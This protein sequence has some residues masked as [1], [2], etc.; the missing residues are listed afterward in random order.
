M[1]F[2]V[3]F[4]LVSGTRSFCG[5]LFGAMP[6]D[7]FIN[8]R[9]ESCFLRVV[10]PTTTTPTPRLELINYHQDSTCLFS[11]TA[12]LSNIHQPNHTQTP[13]LRMAGIPRTT[14]PRL[15]NLAAA[16]RTAPA[17]SGE[18]APT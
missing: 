11:F 14:T 8:A 4:F 2:W 5:V 7:W 6:P 17:A 10:I 9:I 3:G 12:P 18:A 16:A 13:M 1:F 15:L